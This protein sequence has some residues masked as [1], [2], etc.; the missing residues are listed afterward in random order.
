MPVLLTEL[1]RERQKKLKRQRRRN[2]LLHGAALTEQLN[3]VYA[4]E[5]SEFD[6]A[7]MKMQ[8]RSLDREQ[9]KKRPDP[10]GLKDL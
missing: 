1:L 7:L 3:R 2:P 4:R 10:K 8:L 6:A 5:S 9:W